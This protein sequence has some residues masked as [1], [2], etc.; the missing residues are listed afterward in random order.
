M[1]GF[2]MPWPGAEAG[3]EAEE[4]GAAA[5]CTGEFVDHD[6]YVTV[7]EMAVTTRPALIVVAG[8]NKRMAATAGRVADG[9]IGHGL[10]TAKWWDEV[11]RPAVERGSR[12]AEREARPLEHGW[13]LTA[14]NDQDPER[15]IT[16]LR[17][18]IA[19]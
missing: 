12:D 17:R 14:I 7:A 16:D 13:L 3:H 9:V 19:F 15:A 11:V 6:A 1:S 10:F 18:M 8:F 5:F 2:G 4:A